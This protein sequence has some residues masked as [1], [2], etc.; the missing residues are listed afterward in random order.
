M[1]GPVGSRIVAE[2][3]VG[4]IEN[5]PISV[6]K[7][8]PELQFSMPELLAFVNDLNPLGN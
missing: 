6:L 7:K 8:N 5:S 4:L 3:F 2:V 1:L